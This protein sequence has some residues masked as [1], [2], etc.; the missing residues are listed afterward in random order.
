[1]RVTVVGND[2]KSVDIT[3]GSVIS[4]LP[5]TCLRSMDIY[6]CGMTPMQSNAL[7]GLDY[8]PAIKIGIKFKTAW[9]VTAMD[10]EGKPINIVG[11]Q[12][13]TDRP[14]RTIVYPSYSFSDPVPTETTT[15]L[16]ASY[17]WTYD[18]ERLGA[19]IGTGETQ[20]DRQLLTLAIRDL[21][22]VHNVDYDWLYM[23]V[24]DLEK[25]VFAWDW[26]HNPLS[27]GS[28]VS[29]AMACRSS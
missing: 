4:T 7:R 2:D 14:L 27:Q 3:Y 12:S 8:G 21:A 10:K 20:Y 22:A 1:M 25:D 24:D 19:L 13:Y 28:V 17:C 9:W 16:I 23:Q 29:R 15:V 18:A 6:N 26:N 11:G 5:L